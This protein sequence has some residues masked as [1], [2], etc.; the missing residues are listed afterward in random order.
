[1]VKVFIAP[2]KP[3]PSFEDRCS[4]ID[5][6]L[7]NGKFMKHVFVPSSGPEDWRDLLVNPE[8]QWQCGKSAKTLAYCWENGEGFPPEVEAI[9]KQSD[10]L[11]RIELLLA[12]PEWVVKL[13]SRGRQSQNDVWALAKIP[14]GFVS[15]AVE[16]KVDES[17]DKTLRKWKRNASQGKLKRLKYLLSCLD[18]NAEPPGHVHYQLIHRAASA[19]IMAERFG[20]KAAVML[21][22][23]FSTTD[24]RFEDYCEFS[25]H[26][27]GI[28][29][30]IEVLEMVRVKGK[31]PLYI[32]WVRGCKRF[33]S[34]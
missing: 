5:Q 10:A 31:L 29:P 7:Q 26:C 22:H 32:G 1:M 6:Y 15:I 12:I 16:G 20:A 28:S 25:S 17:F 2:G 18:L 23:S 4:S 34:S 24:Q 11:N 8:I 3:P 30:Q 27:F 14:K 21:V 33:L 13:P 19:V 9:L